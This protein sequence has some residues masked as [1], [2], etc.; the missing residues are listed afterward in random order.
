MSIYGCVSVNH[1]EQV[2]VHVSVIIRVSQF[3]HQHEFDCLY[4]SLSVTLNVRVSVMKLDSWVVPWEAALRY[5]QRP[6]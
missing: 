4:T 1:C 5:F 6:I 2:G 3:G